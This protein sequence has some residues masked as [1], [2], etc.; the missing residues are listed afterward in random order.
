MFP[1]EYMY[2]HICF[3]EIVIC[4]HMVTK[5]DLTSVTR[6]SSNIGFADTDAATAAVTRQS[7]YAITV[8]AYKSTRKHYIKTCQYQRCC[9]HPAFTKQVIVNTRASVCFVNSGTYSLVMSHWVF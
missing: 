9:Y 5:T 3:I 6:R 8:T 4:N 2:Q 1:Y 7:A